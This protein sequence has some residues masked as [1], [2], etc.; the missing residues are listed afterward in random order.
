M[1]AIFKGFRC[2]SREEFDWLIEHLMTE[3]NR[4]SAHWEWWKT[5]EELG[6]EYGPEFSV[7][8]GFWQLTRQAHK[9]SVV[10]RLSRLYDTDGSSAS[11]GNFL[12]TLCGAQYDAKFLPPEATS[13]DPEI[14]AVDMGGVSCQDEVVKRLLQVR[15][16]YLAH[17]GKQH[18]MRGT[19]DRLPSLSQEDLST[20]ISRAVTIVQ[21]YREQLKYRYISVS[22]QEAEDFKQLVQLLRAGITTEGAGI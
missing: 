12:Q 4:A 17:R 14:L 22:R 15:N 8:P 10:L 16:Q 18:V 20:L 3:V 1:A 2:R 9:D 6:S 21:R 11:L 13:L 5:M 7:H 19:F